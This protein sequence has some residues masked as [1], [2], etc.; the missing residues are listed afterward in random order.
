MKLRLNILRT[1]CSIGEEE[2]APVVVHRGEHSEEE[3]EEQHN[4]EDDNDHSRVKGQGCLQQKNTIQNLFLVN[5]ST[6]HC[7]HCC[8]NEIWGG[9]CI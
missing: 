7:W 1:H 8:S 9:G 4:D 5:I 3:S 6:M 2:I